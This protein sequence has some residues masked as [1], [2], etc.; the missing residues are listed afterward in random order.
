M[1][2]CIYFAFALIWF[3]KIFNP[4][5]EELSLDYILNFAKSKFRYQRRTQDPVKYLQDETFW[6]NSSAESRQSFFKSLVS[7]VRKG[8]EYASG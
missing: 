5:F 6:E 3:N 2:F 4:E 7:D 1:I 8:S